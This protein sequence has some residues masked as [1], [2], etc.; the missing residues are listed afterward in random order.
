[1]CGR[2]SL[3]TRTSRQSAP[4]AGSRGTPLGSRTRRRRHRA[5]RS[6]RRRPGGNPS[7]KG[8]ECIVADPTSSP[9]ARTCCGPRIRA[10]AVHRN[11]ASS[12]SPVRKVSSESVCARAYF[13][14]LL[15]VTACLAGPVLALCQVGCQLVERCAPAGLCALAF[16]GGK[17]LVAERQP[18]L[19]VGFL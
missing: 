2:A 1:M 11:R 13:L 18:G 19:A 17:S 3:R 4:A 7:R 15:R 16:G 14:L 6:G 8:S 12:R 10:P 9:C 5:V